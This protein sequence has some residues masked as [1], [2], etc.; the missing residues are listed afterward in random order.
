[1]GASTVGASLLSFYRRCKL[2]VLKAFIVLSRF[3]ILGIRVLCYVFRDILRFIDDHNAWILSFKPDLNWR[4]SGKNF[5]VGPLFLKRILGKQDLISL[6]ENYKENI[7]AS[8]S[9]ALPCIVEYTSFESHF[10]LA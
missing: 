2:V 5:F 4:K 8:F 1:M 7:W 6:M 3:L 9:L 10:T